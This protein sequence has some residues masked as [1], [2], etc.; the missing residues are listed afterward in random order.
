MRRTIAV[1]VMMR[2]LP[3]AS[4]E[5]GWVG[6]PAQ[7]LSQWRF[8]SPRSQ[9]RELGQPHP[10][11]AECGANNLRNVQS[12]NEKRNAVVI[13]RTNYFAGSNCALHCRY[14]REPRHTIVALPVFR[15]TARKI[16][17]S[18]VRC[19]SRLSPS[20]CGPQHKNF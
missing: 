8:F 18:A 1:P 9:M 16:S 19:A 14:F 4:R 20:D 17:A 3:Y 5:M 7:K 10:S 6:M 11:T 2:C 13:K 12:F 15:Q